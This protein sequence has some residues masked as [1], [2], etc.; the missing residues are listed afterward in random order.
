MTQL[1]LR[2]LVLASGTAH[3]TALVLIAGKRRK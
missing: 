2:H 1:L 3:G